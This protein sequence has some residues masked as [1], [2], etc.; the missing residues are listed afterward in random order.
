MLFERHR[1]YALGMK[2]NQP[3]SHTMK[4]LL[5]I[6]MSISLIAGTAMLVPTGVYAM[7]KKETKVACACGGGKCAQDC[8]AKKSCDAMKAEKCACGS[9]KTAGECCAK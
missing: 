2:K 9:G 3:R 8:C 6:A 4:K 5:A 7:G 1:V